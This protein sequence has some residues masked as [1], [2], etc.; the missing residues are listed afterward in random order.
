MIGKLEIVADE[1]ALARA[2]AEHF[3]AAATAAIR[4]RGRFNVSLAGGSTPKA[5]YALLR[6]S[7]MR[8][9]VDWESISFYFGDELCV[10]PDHPDSNYG[11]AHT[12]LFEP[13]VLTEEWVYR[14]RGEM[15]PV[16]A[17]GEYDDIVKKMLGPSPAFD[18]IF[19]G[20]GPYGHTAS[21]FPGTLSQIDPDWL[22]APIRVE[23]LNAFRLTLTPRTINGA[24]AIFVVAGGA[25]KADALAHVLTGPREPDVY[26]AQ[27]LHPEHGTLTWLVD[28]AAAKGLSE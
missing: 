20:M 13:L 11:M 1:A 27:I 2:A 14:I 22:V 5:M 12:E 21:L 3:I 17:A 26:P 28:R 19:L 6:E 15:D 10:M 4:E 24:R 25:N 16:D 9:R 8:E 18:L 23:K 7:P